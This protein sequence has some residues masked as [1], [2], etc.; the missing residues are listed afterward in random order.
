MNGELTVPKNEF[1]IKFHNTIEKIFYETEKREEKIFSYG[2]LVNPKN[3]QKDQFY[4]FDYTALCLSRW[5]TIRLKIAHNILIILFQ[6]QNQ[7]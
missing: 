7:I 4:H 3:S 6:R 1:W 2:F 5:F